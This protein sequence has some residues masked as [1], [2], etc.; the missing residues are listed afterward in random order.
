MCSLGVG[1]ANPILDGKNWSTETVS[2][3]PGGGNTAL[4]DAP[5]NVE[6]RNLVDESRLRSHNLGQAR[7]SCKLV[8]KARMGWTFIA[9]RDA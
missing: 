1:P 6:A 3:A 9:G 8:A 5:A 7:T 4:V 2:V